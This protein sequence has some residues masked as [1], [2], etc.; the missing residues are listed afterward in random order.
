[1]EKP[2]PMTAIV[3]LAP[4]GT[5]PPG[6]LPRA[7][8]A[9]T[10]RLPANWLGLRASMPLRRMAINALGDQPVDTTLWNTRM[11][12]YPRRNSCEKN[13]LFTPQLFDLHELEVLAAALERRLAAGAT[14]TFVDIGA[15]VG[16]YSMFVAARGG[17]RARV[18][19]IEPQPGIVE[20][21]AFNLRANPQLN[22][23]LAPV[24]VADREGEIELVIDNR[25]SGG[26]RLNKSA[27]TS[28][29]GEVVQVRCRPL[30]A[31]LG[32]AGIAA[33]DALKIDIEGAED[34]AL[35]PF[36]RE[37]PD[38]LLPEL[39]LI[40]ERTNDWAVDLYPLLRE[41][42]YAASSRSKHNVVFTRGD[43]PSI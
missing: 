12:L 32:D 30:T 6:R 7:L 25:D 42:G 15:N 5:H 37:A 3:D 9:L 33:V 41:R 36:L 22:I 38:S 35:V 43:Q 10:R 34:L 21:L 18:L 40:E 27:A 2:R 28:G 20:R 14:F 31:I 29:D 11:R 4:Y 23:E 16:L 13:A 39:V 17:E 8:L 1:M 26:T 24:A 19:A